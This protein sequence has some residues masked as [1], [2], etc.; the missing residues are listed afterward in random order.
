MS[1]R[2]AVGSAACHQP[3]TPGRLTVEDVRG[4]VIRPRIRQTST[5]EGVLVCLL[6]IGT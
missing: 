4:T 6:R 2:C 3:N 1:A 5:P